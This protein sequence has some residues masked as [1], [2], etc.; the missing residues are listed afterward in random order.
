MAFGNACQCKMAKVGDGGSDI[1]ILLAKGNGYT[2]E[3]MTFGIGDSAVDVGLCDCNHGQYC[4]EEYVNRF[5]EANVLRCE[6]KAG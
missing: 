5:H 3:Q 1:F 6:I 4:E 2:I